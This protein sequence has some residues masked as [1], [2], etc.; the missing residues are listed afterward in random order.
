MK[1]LIIT[2]KNCTDGCCS[3]AIFK[4]KFG[5]NASYLELDHA[6]LDINKDS[7]A[8]KNIDFILSHNNSE[9][10]IADLCLNTEMLNQLLINNN[11]V[12]VLDHHESSIP[13]VE[14]FENRIING[15]KINIHINF[16]KDNTKSGSLLSWNY[17]YPDI[18][19]PMSIRHVSAGDIWKFEFGESTKYFYTG[20]MELFKE[21]QNIPDNYWKK[22]INEPLHYQE[23]IEI[24][25]P[26]REQYMKE[27]YS[28]VPLAEKIILNGIPGLMVNAPKKY[29]SDLGNA[30]ALELNGEGFGLVYYFHEETQIVKCSLRSIAPLA[31]NTIA[32]EF[33]G[34]GHAQASAFSTSS[35]EEF[36]AI[37]YHNS[38][39]L[40]P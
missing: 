35:L 26:L 17:L 12:V 5:E 1:P 20:L 19:P 27:V 38:K 11:K 40:K 24:G 7:N 33:G 25:Q 2:H 18:E 37:I 32:K 29:T 15:E 10:Y 39:K 22:L 16:S 9:V 30:L 34:G 3:K 31:V 8:Q 23:V 4:T 21:P 13:Y 14:H 36:K 28:Y 6:N